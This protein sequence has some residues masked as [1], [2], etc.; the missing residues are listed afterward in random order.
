MYVAILNLNI[1]TV[2]LQK[3]DRFFYPE[4][5]Q[6][7]QKDMATYYDNNTVIYLNGSF[8]KAADAKIDL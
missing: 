4:P 2:R 8:V 6:L 5:Q 3:A 7:K 1:Q